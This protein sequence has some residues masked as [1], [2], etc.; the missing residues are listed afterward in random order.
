MYEITDEELA[1]LEAQSLEEILADCE[2]LVEA[3]NELTDEQ[4]VNL[5]SAADSIPEN[6]QGDD[7]CRG[8]VIY[9]NFNREG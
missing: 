5:L 9:V 4:I 7:S 8:Q 1:E 3:N 2:R 6:S